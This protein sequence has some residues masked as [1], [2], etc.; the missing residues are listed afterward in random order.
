VVSPANTDSRDIYETLDLALRIGEVVLS[1]GAGAADVGATMLSVANT[2]GLRGATATVTFTELVLSYQASLDDA[3]ITQV[4]HVQYRVIYYDHLPSSTTSC[5][6]SLTA[7]ST[8]IRLV[9]G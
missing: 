5:M 6:S 1:S 4:R 3:T 7:R 9:S 8:V 2:C